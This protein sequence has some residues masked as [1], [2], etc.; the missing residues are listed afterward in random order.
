MYGDMAS[1]KRALNGFNQGMLCLAAVLPASLS[2]ALMRDKY[3]EYVAGRKQNVRD[4]TTI[5]D[6]KE[7]VQAMMDNMARIGTFG[8]FGEIPNRWVNA[9]STQR[10]FDLD[11]RI[12]FVNS[13]LNTQ[14]A[15]ENWFLQ[16]K[17]DFQSVG[18]PLAQALGGNGY[19]QYADVL[20]NT[21]GLD[22]QESRVSFR[23]GVNNYLRVAG[24]EL[25]M[26]V[27]Q[28][29]NAGYG[30]AMPNPVKPYI[31]Q[32]IISGYAN[33]SSQFQTAYRE[34]LRVAREEGKT[35]PEEYIKN[36][37]EAY[38]PLRLVFRTLPTEQD[39]RNLLMKMDD[40][41]RQS[42]GEAMRMYTYYASQIGAKVSFAKASPSG[43]AVSLPQITTPNLASI[44]SMAAF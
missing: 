6:P 19:L 22:N 3:D 12:F 37:Y 10:P 42:V 27:R 30:G 4:L 24:K 28:D 23:I 14:R 18:R 8:L 16:G 29:S 17:F 35:N 15:V 21:L 41:G 32:M 40:R 39:Y 2:Y 44:R 38:N 31:G 34:A 26:D 43:Q 25:R 5:S 36:S 20:N 11:G 9:D 1:A 13:I 33:D 7:A